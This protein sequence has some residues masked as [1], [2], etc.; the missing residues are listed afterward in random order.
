M[1]ETSAL[2]VLTVANLRYQLSLHYQITQEKHNWPSR[3]RLVLLP[4]TSATAWSTLNWS[5]TTSSQ[6]CSKSHISPSPSFRVISLTLFLSKLSLR[7]A[8]LSLS[9]LPRRRPRSLLASGPGWDLL[10]FCSMLRR[11]CSKFVISWFIALRLFLTWVKSS[12]GSAKI[13]T[14]SGRICRSLCRSRNTWFLFL[15]ENEFIEALLKKV[16]HE[17]VQVWANN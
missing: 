10:G 12:S 16:F 6:N 14:S 11:F 15:R 4:Q 3:P 7:T 5:L 9:S 1:L 2:K 17:E 8:M 13:R